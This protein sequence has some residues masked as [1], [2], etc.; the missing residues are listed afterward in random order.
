MKIAN[1]YTETNPRP[2]KYE[3]DKIST[4]KFSFMC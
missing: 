1:N 4:K 3:I 2:S